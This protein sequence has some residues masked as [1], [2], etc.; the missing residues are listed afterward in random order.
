MPGRWAAETGGKSAAI[1]AARNAAKAAYLDTP[2]K[3]PKSLGRK[4]RSWLK[5][6]FKKAAKDVRAPSRSSTRRLRRCRRRCRRRA[7]GDACT[8]ALD[9]A[10]AD[11]DRRRR[12]CDRCRA[13][14]RF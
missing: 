7:R 3:V 8:D 4:S 12:R 6:P 14:K 13:A 1:A 2:V 9:D 11:G 10:A 5:W